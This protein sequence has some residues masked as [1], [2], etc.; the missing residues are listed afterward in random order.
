MKV[1]PKAKDKSS[2]GVLPTI[3]PEEISQAVPLLRRMMSDYDVATT[4]LNRSFP[5]PELSLSAQALRQQ[6]ETTAQQVFHFL[7]RL[8]TP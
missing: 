4:R 8:E 5:T 6:L 1:K 7:R 2:N 3:T